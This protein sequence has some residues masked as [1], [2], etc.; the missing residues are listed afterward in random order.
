MIDNYF[1]IVV[2]GKIEEDVNFIMNILNGFIRK[3]EFFVVDIYVFLE[4]VNEWII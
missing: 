2:F 4:N 1:K 3:M